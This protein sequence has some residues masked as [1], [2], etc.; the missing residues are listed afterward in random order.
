MILVSKS[1]TKPACGHW[2]PTSNFILLRRW[3]HVAD[4]VPSKRKVWDSVE[5]AVK[6]VKAGDT[7]LCGGFGL[8]GTP[9]TLLTAL[10]K[11]SDINNLNLTAVSNNAGAKDF[12]LGE[13]HLTPFSTKSNGYAVKLIRAN[14]LKKLMISYLGGNKYLESMYLHGKIALEIVPQGTLVERIRAH[15][16]VNT[17]FFFVFFPVKVVFREFQ[18]FIPLLELPPL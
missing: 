5:D 12:G 13:F 6:D 3:Y 10:S 4:P 7:L 17:V 9:E 8:C 15:A 14:G 11:R 18:P 1:L 2:R 16:A